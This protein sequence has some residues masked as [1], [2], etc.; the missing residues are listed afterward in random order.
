MITVRIRKQGGSA[1]ISIPQAVLQALDLKI[2]DTVSLEVTKQK[3]V[4]RPV[5]Q[6]LRKRYTLSEL[7]AGVTEEKM[8]RIIE[9][10]RWA[11]DG[12]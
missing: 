11:Q 10:T 3:L 7:L 12:E 6:R 4:V 2:G 9:E 1:V 8:S 5:R